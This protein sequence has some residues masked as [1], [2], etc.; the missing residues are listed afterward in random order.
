MSGVQARGGPGEV[1]EA[2]QSLFSV[3][4]CEAG[5]NQMGWERTFLLRFMLAQGFKKRACEIFFPPSRAPPPFA[6]SN[7]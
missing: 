7:R 3:F 1:A 6:C 4:P 2:E 5:E